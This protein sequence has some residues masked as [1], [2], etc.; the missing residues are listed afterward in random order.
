MLNEIGIGEW[1]LGR[2][3]EVKRG[4]LQGLGCPSI[5]SYVTS[6]GQVWTR[7][8]VSRL[9]TSTLAFDHGSCGLPGKCG[10]GGKKARRVPQ[11]EEEKIQERG[12]GEPC[13]LR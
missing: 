3:M 7:P 8:D 1:S 11:G 12:Q 6:Q 4:T 9:N 13:L 10:G 2:R 5:D